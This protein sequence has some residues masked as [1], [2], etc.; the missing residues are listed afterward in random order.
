MKSGKNIGQF[1]YGF[2]GISDLRSV[3]NC[4]EMT[5]YDEKLVA[6]RNESKTAFLDT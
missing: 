5:A 4:L 1:Q 2:I 6:N 3:D